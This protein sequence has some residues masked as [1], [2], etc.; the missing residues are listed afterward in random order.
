MACLLGWGDGYERKLE[1]DGGC[2]TVPLRTDGGLKTS[3]SGGR[4]GHLLCMEKSGL[5]LDYT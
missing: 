2:I 4:H 3:T 5:R 1:V